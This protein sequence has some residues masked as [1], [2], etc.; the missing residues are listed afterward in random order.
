MAIFLYPVKPC[1][2]NGPT[3]QASEPISS[4]PSEASIRQGPDSQGP[5]NSKKS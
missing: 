2:D 1:P 5:D 4:V 3:F